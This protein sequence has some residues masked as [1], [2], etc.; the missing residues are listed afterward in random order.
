MRHDAH[1]VEELS[2]H[3][4]DRWREL[5]AG[6]ASENEATKLALA[7]FREGDLLAR[8]APHEQ[9]RRLIQNS[10]NYEEALGKA[11]TP[12]YSG[13][14]VSAAQ[15]K[16]F[17]DAIK[18]SF[19]AMN[20]ALGKRGSLSLSSVHELSIPEFLSK[21]DA[22]FTLNQDLLLEFHYN[23]GGHPAWRWIGS[24]YPGIEPEVATP[25]DAGEVVRV[26]R[27]G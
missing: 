14:D 11:R 2:Q 15:L 24:Y 21:F 18:E 3:L 27:R 10:E 7:G 22:I 20:I 9:L 16:I 4:E 23:A 13:I 26:E 19:W 25:L 1:D 6:G 17:E 8:L 12:G 5:V